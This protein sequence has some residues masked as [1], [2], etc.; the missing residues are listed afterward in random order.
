MVVTTLQFLVGQSPVFAAKQNGNTRLT[1]ERSRDGSQLARIYQRPGN[2]TLT[3]TGTENQ[4]TIR[5]CLIQGR[6]HA[7]LF[8]DIGRTR[9]SG[10]GIRMWKALGLYQTKI[11]DT[12]ILH[13]SRDTTDITGMG[14]VNQYDSDVIRHREARR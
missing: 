2:M 5:L 13:R 4:P 3:C 9:G 12:H 6:H 14:C 7:G 11:T 10:I 1:F 8:K